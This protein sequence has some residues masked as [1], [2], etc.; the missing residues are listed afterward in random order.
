MYRISLCI[1]VY[2]NKTIIVSLGSVLF[3]MKKR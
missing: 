3:F 1:V 2:I